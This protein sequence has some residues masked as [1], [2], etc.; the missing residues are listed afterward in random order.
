[1]AQ[2]PYNSTVGLSYNHISNAGTTLVKGNPGLLGTVFVNG[3]TAG[4]TATMFDQA[5]TVTGTI[6][7]GAITL[8]GT[9]FPLA[10]LPYDLTLKNGLAIVTTGGIDLTVTF[11]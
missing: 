9:T 5:T 11:R 6:E 1:M 3:G 10:P 2:P 8:T 4:A 7:I